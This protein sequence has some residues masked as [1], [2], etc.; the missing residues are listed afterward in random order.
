MKLLDVRRCTAEFA[1]WHVEFLWFQEAESTET[2]PDPFYWPPCTYS[3]KQKLK[4]IPD[5]FIFSCTEVAAV[6]LL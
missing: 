2:E 4:I 5:R 6:T 3:E 1:A